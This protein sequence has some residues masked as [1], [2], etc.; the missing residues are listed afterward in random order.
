M[1]QAVPE[2]ISKMDWRINNLTWTNAPFTI[3][4]TS[5]VVPAGAAVTQPALIHW[6]TERVG[7]TIPN[8]T[9]LFLGL[10]QMYRAEA[11][12]WLKKCLASRDKSGQLPDSDSFAFYERMMAS[13]VFAY[14]ALEAFVNEELP[15]SH[16]HEVADKNCTRRF[17]KEQIE[18]YLNLDTKLGDVLPPVLNV[19]SPKGGRLWS[20]YEKLQSLRDRIIHMKTK[21][22]DSRG[23]DKSSIWN[24]LLAHPLPETYGTAKNL[25]KYFLDAKGKLPR[26]FEKCPF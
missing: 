8:A 4:K 5:N 14:S 9:A 11:E 12:Q 19:T 3:P 20:E 26:W 1:S 18:R 21:D 13:V 24:A 7:I 23:E 15:D 2:H 10:S 6:G 25:M 17:N 16:V 22:R